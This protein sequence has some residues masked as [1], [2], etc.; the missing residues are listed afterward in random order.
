M[1]I[2]SA[3]FAYTLYKEQ[4]FKQLANNF[5]EK[6][7]VEKGNTLVYKNVNYS[8]SPKTIELA[9]LKKVFNETEI[10]QLNEKLRSEGLSNTKLLIRQNAA[11]NLEAFKEDILNQVNKKDNALSERDKSI[12]L[13]EQKLSES[14][15]DNKQLL[16]EI[17]IFFP[18]ISSVSV[19]KQNIASLDSINT[20]TVFL[21]S[22]NP[23]LIEADKDKLRSWMTKKLGIDSI[24]ITETDK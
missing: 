20:S 24:I 5:I 11:N 12:A 22:S 21:Y 13:L 19:S 6:E 16:S 14:T 9:F 4:Q 17:K 3:F 8:S 7:F 2:P 15:F 18:T 1:L 10:Q 23:K